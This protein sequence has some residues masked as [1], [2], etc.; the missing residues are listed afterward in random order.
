MTRNAHEFVCR[1]NEP[2]APYTTLRIGGN[3]RYF[4]S[5]A[6]VE[7]L[8]DATLFAREKN[9]PI[10]VLGGG[11]NVLIPDGM[12]EGVVVYMQ[13]KGILYENI[14]TQ[15]VL[16]VCAGGESWD[17][18][19]ADTVARGLS[20]LENLS[21]IPGSVGASP[22]QNIGAYGVEVGAH[23]AYVEVFDTRTLV[24]KKLSCNEC[25]FGYRDSIFKSEKG[26]SYT[27]TRVAYTLSKNFTPSMEYKDV[28][29]FFSKKGTLPQNPSNIREAVLQ[30]RA[31]K[32]PD[33][34]I[35]G[36]AGSFFKN[37]II[38]KGVYESLLQKYPEMPSFPVDSVR[39]KIP[40]AWVLDE[41]C[42]FK[43]FK[44]G[45][46]FLFEQQP[47]VL[48]TEHGATADEV[49]TFAEHIGEIVFEKTGIQIEKEV[50]MMK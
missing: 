35:F 44:E 3:A 8:R 1:E 33:M 43:G 34:S 38:A 4:A 28:S 39:V 20:G 32:F 37:P 18:F 13:M 30:I 12:Y 2:L 6:S 22:V 9:L 47:L 42:N 5:V 14:D 19:V 26:K 46:V 10:F 49:Y 40:L 31:Q 23:I 36:T 25:R 15:T 24:S 50:V 17:T 41:V 21:G 7:E 16:A 11:S 27:V 29:L 45:R 48:V